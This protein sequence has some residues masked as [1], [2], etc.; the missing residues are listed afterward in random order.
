M[1]QNFDLADQY[2][3][4]D[5]EQKI[6]T[7]LAADPGLYWRVADLLTAEAFTS[8]RDQYRAFVEG[9][10]P[11]AVCRDGAPA[12]DLVKWA[13]EL[14]DLHRK[15]DL[16]EVLQAAF[17]D[18]PERPAPDLLADLEAN[19]T[20]LQNYAREQKTG[21]LVPM[22]GL[23]P[24]MLEDVGRRR[25]AV[26]A[27]R[28]VGF[29][30]GLRTID[31]LLG[32]LQPGLHLLA[33]EPGA[34]KTT[35]GLQIGAAVAAAPAPVLFVS[36][37]ETL[38]RLALKAICQKAGLV[39][40]DY[41]DGYRDQ[42]D[43]VQAVRD[44]GQSLAGFYLLEG[45][46]RLTALDLKAR[47]LQAMAAWKADRCLVIVDYI[48]RWASTRRESAEYR[49]LVNQ[50]VAELREL[51]MRLDSP[52]L[53]ISSQNRAGQ[54]TAAMTSLKESADLEYS[55]DTLLFLTEEGTGGPIRK[56]TLTVGKNRFGDK[57]KVNLAFK[58]AQGQFFEEDKT[59]GRY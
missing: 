5:L 54:G 42:A 47:A 13:R 1:L 57:G 9:L 23:F 16:S 41:A 45:N 25:E 14:A 52:V 20:R 15:R 37:E 29:P 35:L 58:P 33:A 39:S 24:A 49:L 10:D 3:N 12:A 53:A 44:H 30:T 31:K 8:H 36:F 22:T 51:A 6:L 50:V 34:G 11:T 18:L 7:T 4:P 56:M 21:Q 43:L 48:Q 40:K 26:K 2:R 46:T 28:S 55:A 32:G 27:G 17:R 59:N 19:L 38:P